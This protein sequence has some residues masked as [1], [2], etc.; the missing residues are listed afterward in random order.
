MQ[1]TEYILCI[2]YSC[3]LLI[4]VTGVVQ[5]LGSLRCVVLHS[6]LGFPIQHITSGCLIQAS[7]PVLRCAEFDNVSSFHCDTAAAPTNL[8]QSPVCCAQPG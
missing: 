1:I 3:T 6:K 7:F 4:P 2:G 8:L 5:R